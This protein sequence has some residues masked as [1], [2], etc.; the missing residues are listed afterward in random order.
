LPATVVA[1]AMENRDA[2][3]LRHDVAEASADAAGSGEMDRA[4]A[5]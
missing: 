5:S 1:F 3:L 2:V 4:A